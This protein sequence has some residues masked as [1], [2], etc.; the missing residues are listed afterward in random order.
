MVDVTRLAFSSLKSRLEW[1]E[2]VPDTLRRAQEAIR[3]A[4]HLVV[5]FPI[6]LGARLI[7]TM[8]LPSFIYRW[9]FRAHGTRSF[10]RNVLDLVGVGPIHETLIGLVE[11]RDLAT[12]ERWLAKRTRKARRLTAQ[13]ADSSR[14]L[15]LPAALLIAVAL[16]GCATVVVPTQVRFAALE[17]GANQVRLFDV[18]PGEAANTA[19]RVRASI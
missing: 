6:W 8:G 16:G 11:D 5:V 2:A 18:R 9:N 1:E 7:V 12:R 19:K 13:L 3:W 15:R 17:P 4:E 10:E 14:D